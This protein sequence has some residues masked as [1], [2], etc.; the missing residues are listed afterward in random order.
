VKKG[1]PNGFH[2]IFGVKFRRVTSI[3]G[4]LSRF[5]LDDWQVTCAID[6]M[7]SELVLPLQKGW[8]TIEQLK[9]M[10]LERTRKAAMDESRRRMKAKQ[11]IGR[12]AHKVIHDYYAGGQHKDFIEQVVRGEPDL[13]AALR[14]FLT[15][16]EEFSVEMMFSERLVFSFSRKYAGTT[17]LQARIV[18]PHEH[19]SEDPPKRIY[20]V[21]FKTGKPDPK[22]LLQIAAYTVA[23]EEMGRF[24]A[25]GAGL[26]YLD[27]ETGRPRWKGY[28]RQELYLPFMMFEKL[29]GFVELEDERKDKEDFEEDPPADNASTFAAAPPAA[30]TPAGPPTFE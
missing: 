10:D 22:D 13:A 1:E 4:R 3:L 7:M 21:D 26:V 2:D 15:W 12:R 14:A 20:V 18:L 29:K 5:G 9:D 19:V 6:F 11:T 8:L 28:T 24:E 17:D 30:A 25:D 23:V 16:E 27:Q